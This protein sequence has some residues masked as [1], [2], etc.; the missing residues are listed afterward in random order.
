MIFLCDAESRTRFL[1][2][3]VE[4]FKLWLFVFSAAVAG[5]AGA[6]AR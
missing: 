6:V 2:Y 5:I 1:G 4:S 3:P